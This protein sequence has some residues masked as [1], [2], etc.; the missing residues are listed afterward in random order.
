MSDTITP[1]VGYCYETRGAGVVGPM[2]P[3]GMNYVV[4]DEQDRPGF[5]RS[6]S[7]QK[8]GMYIGRESVWDLVKEIPQEKHKRPTLKGMVF[9]V[10]FH[11]YHDLDHG[12]ALASEI[13]NLVRANDPDY[14]ELT[15]GN[16]VLRKEVDDLRAQAHAPIDMCNDYYRKGLSEG[17]ALGEK[18]REVLQKQIVEL[19]GALREKTECCDRMSALEK[20]IASLKSSNHDLFHTAYHDPCVRGVPKSNR[21]SYEQLKDLA[22]KALMPYTGVAQLEEPMV[23]VL[24]AVLRTLGLFQE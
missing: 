14:K 7:L 10:L 21:V 3:T 16:C 23:R 20:A 15:T 12:M 11:H 4:G 8:H 5:C 1:R 13:I 6:Y 17:N 2:E 9:N 19:K 18:A 24:T 22:H